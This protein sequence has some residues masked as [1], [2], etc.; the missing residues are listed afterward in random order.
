MIMMRRGKIITRALGLALMVWI[1]GFTSLASASRQY[2]T[3]PTMPPPSA[4]PSITPF[5]TPTNV[6]EFTATYPQPSTTFT[7]TTRA[8]PTQTGQAAV[9]ET[10]KTATSSAIESPGATSTQ[11][12]INTSVS[13]PTSNPAITQPEGSN[14]GMYGLICGGLLLVLVIVLGILLVRRR[15]QA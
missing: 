6:P 2:Q 15:R 1:C 3:V 5:Y 9:S 7:P 12:M 14:L 13:L 4:T 10:V 11:V 8:S